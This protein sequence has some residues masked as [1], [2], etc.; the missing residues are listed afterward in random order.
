MSQRR[1][2]GDEIEYLCSRCVEKSDDAQMQEISAALERVRDEVYGYQFVGSGTV[3]SATLMQPTA[4]V[5]T[6]G[7]PP[8]ITLHIRSEIYRFTPQRDITAFEASRIM[9]ILIQRLTASIAAADIASWWDD[10]GPDIWR[11][12]SAI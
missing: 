12:F 11:H 1:F 2:T 3:T 7:G 5:Q 6:Q 9:A 10:A 8:K 4:P